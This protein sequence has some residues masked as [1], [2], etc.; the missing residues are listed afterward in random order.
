MAEFLTPDNVMEIG[1]EI[2]QRILETATP[3]E[4]L[5]GLTNAERRQLLRM[6]QEELDTSSVDEE[7]SSGVDA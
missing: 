5:T 7:N 4:R 3:E 1:E 6:L 2:R